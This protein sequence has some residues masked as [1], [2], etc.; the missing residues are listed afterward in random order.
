MR[1]RRGGG[2]TWPVVSLLSVV[3]L[4]ATPKTRAF[5]GDP[6]AA[7][8]SEAAAL[9]SRRAAADALKILEPLLSDP[10]VIAKDDLLALALRQAGAAWFQ[11]NEYPKAL[12]N[13][14]RGLVISRRLPDRSTEAGITFGIAQVFKNQ[15]AYPS[16]LEQATAALALQQAT[17]EVQASARTYLL[18]GEIQD[19]MGSH[20][21]ALESYRMAVPLFDRTSRPASFLR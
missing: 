2:L 21:Q 20:R 7:R 11:L 18:I 16:A 5:Q 8:I 17:N 6:P 4:T 13:Y 15:G 9:I 1:A 19:S 3:L 10:A 12:E 14:Q